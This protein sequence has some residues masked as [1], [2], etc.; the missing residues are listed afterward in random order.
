MEKEEYFLARWASNELSPEEKEAFEKSA[1]FSAYNAI[2]KGFDTLKLPEFNEQELFNK[3]L[4]YNKKYQKTNSSSKVISLNKVWYAVAASLL[5]LLGFNWALNYRTT[6]YNTQIA[7]LKEIELPDHS[8]I[9]LS[10]VSTVSF[11][12]KRFLKNRKLELKGQAF[13]EVAKGSRFKVETALGDIEVLGT[14]FDIFVRDK[15][16]E[17]KCYEGK[18]KAT[19]GNKDY[20]LERGMGIMATDKDLKHLNF[21]EDKPYWLSSKSHFEKAPLKEVIK[22]L[23]KQYNISFDSK[24]INTSRKFSGTV[25]HKDLESALRS[26]F[27]PMTISTTID[28]GKILLNKL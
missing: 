25:P 3:Q 8:L 15:K 2:L 4:V 7:E 23:E 13:F 20:L 9:Q 22:F 24:A 19:I 11:N 21:S 5:L 18:V 6:S 27:D 1:D 17:V 10:A 14:K 26:V 28:G 16:I 12:K